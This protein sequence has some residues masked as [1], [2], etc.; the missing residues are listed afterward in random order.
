MDGS[1]GREDGN[2]PWDEELE[3][4]SINITNGENTPNSKT[5][6]SKNYI[7]VIPGTS[8][9]MLLP[10]VYI[11]W[12]DIN[13]N[14]IQYVEN[15]VTE[16]G[17][18]HGKTIVAPNNAYYMRFRCSGTYG[19]TYNHDISINYPSTDHDYHA[20]TGNTY[21]ISW[22]TEAGTVYGGT[23]D[24]VS[25]ELVVD[26]RYIIFDGSEDEIW[27]TYSTTGYRV[28]KTDI[29]LSGNGICNLAPTVSSAAS[30]GVMFNASANYIYFFQTVSEWGVATVADLRAWLATNNVEV[31]YERAEPITYH[32]TP[33][34]VRTLLGQ[35]NVWA[36]TGD[37]SVT[38]RADIQRYIQ[39]MLSQ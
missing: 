10:W 30:Y 3:G 36:D 23:L 6:R 28:P 20:Y 35:N 31:C 38:Y 34:E 39:K 16:D 7:S 9:Y 8:Y 25:G 27:Y 12:Y 4:G 33:M 14:Y 32:L 22:E 37:T 21:P 24:V 26:R 19:T 11:F 17:A 2:Q 5:T 29:G 13:K 18:I 1:A 15:G